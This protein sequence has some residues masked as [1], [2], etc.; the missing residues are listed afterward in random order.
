M[1][2]FYPLKLLKIEITTLSLLTIL[3]SLLVFEGKGQETWEFEFSGSQQSLD[4]NP[5][6]YKLEVWGA[7]G[8]SAH[9]DA[10]G[11]KGGYSAGLVEFSET[12]SI[13]IFV[14]EVGDTL[15]LGS[16]NGGGASG[17]NY[18]TEGGG[19][20][21]IRIAPYNLENRIIVA[22]GGGGATFGSY[23]LSGGPGGGSEGIEGESGYS[24]IGG[25]GGTQTEG[26]V[27]GCCYTGTA[28]GT[29]GQGAGT[30]TYHNAGGGG[31]WYGGGTGAGHAGAGGGSGYT[32]SLLES[33]MIA[34]NELMPSTNN[35]EE[36][37][38]G[39][40][41]N[42]FARITQ[43]YDLG[44]VELTHAT[45]PDSEDGSITI[46]ISGGTPPYSYVW[47]TGATSTT[48]NITDS[49]SG[50]SPGDYTITV[51]DFNGNEVSET[52]TLG[53]ETIDVNIETTMASSCDEISDGTAKANVTGGTAPY[54]YYWSSGEETDS[55]SNLSVGIYSATISDSRGC[56]SE[57]ETAIISS[58]DTENPVAV[59]QN[60]HVYL[61]ADGLAIIEAEDL[62]NGSF[63]DCAIQ[64]MTID[65]SEFSCR[66][67]STGF[68]LTSGNS[69]AVYI[70]ELMSTQQY[71]DSIRVNLTVKDFVGNSAQTEAYVMVIDT[72][73]PVARAKNIE[74]ELNAYGMA[75][76]NVDEIENGSSDNCSIQ[77]LEISKTEFS[78]E[79]LGINE[80]V[81]TATDPSGNQNQ[82]VFTV[83][84]KDN[85]AP[86]IIGP[87]HL[88]GCEG[89]K[90]QYDD[91]FVRDNCYASLDVIS[92]PRSG[93]VL[94]KGIHQVQFK[95]EDH[96]GNISNHLL[97]LQ[98]HES[99]SVNI[100]NTLEVEQG[101]LITLT[102]GQN[103]DYT[104]SWSTG[105]NTPSILLV[106]EE[107]TRVS[108]DVI[109]PDGCSVSDEVFIHI[110]G[111]QNAIDQGEGNSALFFPN[112]TSGELNV[113]LKLIEEIKDL[114]IRIVDISGKMVYQ[115]SMTNTENGQIMTL[116]LSNLANG[117]YLV[118]LHSNS[119]NQ[120]ERIVKH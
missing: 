82:D 55:I 35:T 88:M 19:A 105:D 47:S 85:E 67:L 81:L 91:I 108:V 4:L 53:P 65:I 37:I 76:I 43:I 113:G 101:E 89:Q 8:G 61:D 109:S 107:D 42:G 21:D 66:N 38:I 33:Q 18:G 98:V 112:P 74:V 70:D 32:G 41:G 60:I 15:G 2:P 115:R 62:D 9:P 84:I 50:L 110:L 79:D 39:N 96:A 114:K 100:G 90:A 63:D 59:A 119:F 106:A 3:M 31:G 104:Y 87:D 111:P 97:T 77:N 72:I 86:L 16:F 14:G 40:Q 64:E 6:K 58:N 92:G 95:A 17:T 12:Q 117:V 10:P 78:C 24:F 26:G 75:S 1:N 83:T 118:N 80:L 44:I 103:Q 30:L 45:C 52:Y 116:N 23:P 57:E 73:S 28:A 69:E 29:F 71:Q 56:V 11:G 13:Q 46:F 49:L 120:T 25:Q 48:E 27:G 7:Q 22:G 94:E 68:S 51:T 99:P 36:N 93:D 5:G 102:A 34:G 54:D 20:T